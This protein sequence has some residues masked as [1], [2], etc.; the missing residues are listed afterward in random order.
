MLPPPALTDAKAASPD[1]KAQ[2]SLS[3]V[4]EK[5]QP[6]EEIAEKIQLKRILTKDE[7]NALSIALCR[8]ASDSKSKCGIC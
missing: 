6:I 8:D 4:V 1:K 3:E 5:L 2:P 7:V